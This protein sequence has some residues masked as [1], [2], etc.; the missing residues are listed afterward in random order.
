MFH[1][2]VLGF[3]LMSQ[4]FISVEIIT[5]SLILN[6]IQY[7]KKCDENALFEKNFFFSNCHQV[8]PYK[9]IK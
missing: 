9:F 2:S 7:D 4:G 3:S 1:I 6:E 8:I 5:I